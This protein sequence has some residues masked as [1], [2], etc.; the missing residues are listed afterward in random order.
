VIG[1]ATGALAVADV[2]DL[3][4][5]RTRLAKEIGALEQDIDRTAKK[6]ANPDFVARAP[7]EV[8]EENRER[9]NAAEQAK[10]KLAAALIRL[11]AVG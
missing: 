5:E 11:E 1:E 2:I 8:V 6:L 7:E 4:A 9:L 3:A 10:V